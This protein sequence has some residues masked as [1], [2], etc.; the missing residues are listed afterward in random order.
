MPSQGSNSEY[1]SLTPLEIKE[2][3]YQ[4]GVESY[5]VYSGIL[6]FNLAITYHSMSLLD[7][8]STCL[9]LQAQKIYELAYRLLIQELA[10]WKAGV[11]LGVAILNNLGMISKQVKQ[12]SWTKQCF[13]HLLSMLL[14]IRECGC[15]RDALSSS[16]SEVEGLYSNIIHELNLLKQ[17]TTA[18]SA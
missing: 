18:P 4:P 12:T 5:T 16:S 10:E 9:A 14:Y 8:E 17:A 1:L 2:D 11:L 3:L 13:E 15:Y 6:L 7:D